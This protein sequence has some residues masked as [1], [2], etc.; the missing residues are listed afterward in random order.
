ML[1]ENC[2]F[3]SFPKISDP[4]GTLTYVEARE[5]I[6]FEVKRVFWLYAVP[7]GQTR[8]GHAHKEL[9]QVLVCLHGSF[10]VIVA[11]GIS[12]RRFRLCQPST[13]V[14]IPPL[15]W[16]TEVNFSP[17]A[18]CIVLASDHY[19]EGDYYRDYGAWV[20]AVNAARSSYLRT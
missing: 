4:R 12:E 17:G 14:Y 7:D 5:H 13:G 16:D 19:D 15:I 8:G 9:H 10:D 6:P 18:V 2:R 3:L 11:D 1:V 20:V